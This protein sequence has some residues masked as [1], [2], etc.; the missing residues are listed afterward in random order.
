MFIGIALALNAL[1]QVLGE[2]P[3]PPSSYTADMTSVT[4]DDTSLTADET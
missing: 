3:A 4:A 1:S 2:P